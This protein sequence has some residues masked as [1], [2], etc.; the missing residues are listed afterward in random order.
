M[1]HTVIYKLLPNRNCLHVL[2][3]PVTC[4]DASAGCVC[5]SEVERHSPNWHFLSDLQAEI[6]GSSGF[7]MRGCMRY[8]SL[9]SVLLCSKYSRHK[10]WYFCRTFRRMCVFSYACVLVPLVTSEHCEPLQAYLDHVK[11]F[12][13]LVQGDGLSALLLYVQLQMILQ[14]TANSWEPAEG[15]RDMNVMHSVCPVQTGEN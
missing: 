11:R 3:A 12:L 15:K 4:Y 14:V 2:S 7:L 13:G 10:N 5:N 6:K 1:T 9:V 8:L